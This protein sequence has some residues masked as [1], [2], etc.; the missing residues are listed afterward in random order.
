MSKKPPLLDAR[1]V[2]VVDLLIKNGAD[3]EYIGGQGSSLLM[4]AAERGYVDIVR[5]LLGVGANPNTTNYGQSALQKA[6]ASD[7]LEIVQLL[8]DAG[9]DPNMQDPDDWDG[10]NELPYS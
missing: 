6:A 8:L 9:A 3:Y 10:T 5:Y 1:S 7:E 4:F 2:E